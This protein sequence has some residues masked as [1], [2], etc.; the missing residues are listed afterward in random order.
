MVKA[1]MFRWVGWIPLAFVPIQESLGR[2]R[3][4]RTAKQHRKVDLRKWPL[5][6]VAILSPTMNL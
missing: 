1:P 4:Y 6:V 2:K 3:C 5:C